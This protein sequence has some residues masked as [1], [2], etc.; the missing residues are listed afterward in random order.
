[1]STPGM[2]VQDEENSGGRVSYYEADILCPLHRAPYTAEC[3]DIIAALG[4]NPREANMFKELWRGA[5]ARQ[6]LMKEGNSPLRGA[7]KLCF[8]ADFN[9]M[10]VKFYHGS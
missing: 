6:G 1:M 9:Y 3:S 4:M 5:A 10:L 2:N 8:F 7:E